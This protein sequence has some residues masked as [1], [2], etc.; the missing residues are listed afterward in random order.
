[1]PG[2]PCARCST[3]SL[4]SGFVPASDTLARLANYSRLIH[5]LLFALEVH[6]ES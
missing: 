6:H 2:A 5:P 4:L 1:M 3:R